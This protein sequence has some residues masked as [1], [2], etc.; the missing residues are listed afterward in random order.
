MPATDLPE[1]VELRTFYDATPDNAFTIRDLQG[2]FARFAVFTEAGSVIL[3]TED[4]LNAYYDPSREHDPPSPNVI[5]SLQTKDIV[6]LAFG[7]HH[8]HALRTNGTVTS[9]GLE[10]SR[11]GALGLGEKKHSLL[12]GVQVQNTLGARDRLPDG[13]GRTVWFEP[14]MSVWLAD[15]MK[16]T[17]NEN[18][19]MVQGTVLRPGEVRERA[20]MLYQGNPQMRQAYADF[21]ER[22]GAKWENNVTN[23]GGM[24]AYFVLKI[25]AAGWHSATLVLVDED[26]AERARED[27][28]VVLR[29][30]SPS[31]SKQSFDS[32][33][34]IHSPGE[35]LSN[36]VYGIY[37]WF[38]NMGRRFLGLVE[39]NSSREEL[40]RQP[41]SQRAS[42]T[43][44][45]AHL[46]YS[47][48]GKPFPRLRLPDGTPMPGEV[49][50]TE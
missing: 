35:Q 21:F 41:E 17:M 13:E 43:E 30:L 44:D 25:A 37:E 11:C 40:S 16:K 8:F 49:P 20:T 3:G 32:Y 14:L 6:S 42:G 47:W 18:E 38:W 22:E 1:P 15:E 2:A 5:P 29:E 23:E 33:E 9:F 24:G 12:R 4:L 39:R 28:I 31:P 19:Q 26:I 45:E 27:H 36:A 7:D 34:V 48:T 46:T 50:L 10:I